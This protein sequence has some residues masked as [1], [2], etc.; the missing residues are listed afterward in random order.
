MQYKTEL[1]C[2]SNVVSFCGRITPEEIV[3]RYV[4]HGY[5]SLVLTEHINHPAFTAP[6]YTGGDSLEGQVAFYMRGY[7]ALLEA[8]RGKL[9]ILLGAE[10][11][12]L[13]IDYLVYGVEEKHLPLLI[14]MLSN[15]DRIETISPRVREAGLLLVQAH[16]FRHGTRVTNPTLLDG[17]EAYNGNLRIECH[18]DITR[19]WAK[20]FGLIATSGT[21]THHADR[22]INGGIVTDF[23]ITTNEE[24]LTVL[25]NGDYALLEDGEATSL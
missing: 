1:H 10:I 17:I 8:A 15:D 14:T 24:L 21:D 6:H 12:S 16:P 2:H 22:P 23:P 7:R 9:N 11:C 3:A 20:H 4:E 25:K 13:G 18:N 5:T 19:Y